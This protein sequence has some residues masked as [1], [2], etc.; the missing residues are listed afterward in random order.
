MHFV[1]VLM[2]TPSVQMHK[3]TVS[4]LSVLSPA[5][6]EKALSFHPA[7]ERSF[8]SLTVSVMVFLDTLIS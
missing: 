8:S 2:Y 3:C 7:V 4:M 6:S 5:A 1:A